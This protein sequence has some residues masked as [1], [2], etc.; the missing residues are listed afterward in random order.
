[1]ADHNCLAVHRLP[2]RH[3]LLLPLGGDGRGGAEVQQS[4]HPLSQHHQREGTG[5]TVDKTNELKQQR[6]ISKEPDFEILI[7][8]IGAMEEG[9]GLGKNRTKIFGELSTLST[10]EAN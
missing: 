3:Q 5:I 10:R 1:M 4:V 2:H 9:L 6:D 7:L 8:V